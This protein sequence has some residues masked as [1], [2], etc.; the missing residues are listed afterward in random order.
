MSSGIANP[1][2]QIQIPLSKCKFRSANANPAQSFIPL[3]VISQI[4]YGQPD[5]LRL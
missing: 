4:R 3:S 5:Y 1:A 2:Q